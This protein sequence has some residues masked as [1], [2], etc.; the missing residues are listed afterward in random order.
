MR[1]IQEG[2]LELAGAFCEPEVFNAEP[3]M[4]TNE[5]ECKRIATAGRRVARRAQGWDTESAEMG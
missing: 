5:H 2:V 4:N 3:R 1:V